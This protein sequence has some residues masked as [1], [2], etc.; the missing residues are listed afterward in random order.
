MVGPEST[1]QVWRI[2]L[3]LLAVALMFLSALGALGH[4]NLLAMFGG[5]G[6]L[7]VAI[8]AR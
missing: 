5:L 8:T 2:I 7:L 4:A 6:F 1:S 3:A